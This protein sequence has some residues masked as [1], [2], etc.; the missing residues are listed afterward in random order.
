MAIAFGTWIVLARAAS[1]PCPERDASTKA[2]KASESSSISSSASTRKASARS[3]EAAA[4][5]HRDWERAATFCS[6]AAEAATTAAAAEPLAG[7]GCADASA[8]RRRT[9]RPSGV[10]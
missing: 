5:A 7:A 6:N 3:P 2:R 4:P 10:I 9:N 8:S 1:T